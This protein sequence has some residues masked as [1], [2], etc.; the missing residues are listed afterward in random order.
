MSSTFLGYVIFS[1]V[2][3]FYFLHVLFLEIFNRFSTVCIYLL[4]LFSPAALAEILK[5]AGESMTSI[6]TAMNRYVSLLEANTPEVG[7]QTTSL[8]EHLYAALQAA[9]VWLSWQLK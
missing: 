8:Y 4:L 2:R 7:V 5:E 9:A 1:Y 3:L 6:Q